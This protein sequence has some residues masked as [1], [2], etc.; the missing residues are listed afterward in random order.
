[1][2]RSAKLAL[3]LFA[4]VSF[5]V[6]AE[7]KI[8]YIDSDAVLAGYSGTKAAEEKLRQFYAKLEQEATEKQGRIKQMQDELQKQALLISEARKKE[9]EK[10]LQDSLI[11]YQQFLQE[12]M[13]QQ[14]AAA[15]KQS[16]LMQ[17]IIE[18]INVAIK[19]LSEKENFD[20]IFD[21]KA[22]LLFGK[23]AYDITQKLI[24]VLNSGK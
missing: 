10:S 4:L 20:F 12:K 1:M 13:G 22:G 2:K 15:Q 21:A 19:E 17:P 3:A 6:A 5:T 24:S 9:L 16:E 8:G 18:K 14:G 23:P 7:L 11:V